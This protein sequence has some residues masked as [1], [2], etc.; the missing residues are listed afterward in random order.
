MAFV[1][2]S[3]KKISKQKCRWDKGGTN[4]TE[5]FKFLRVKRNEIRILAYYFRT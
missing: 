3:C 1:D 2:I 4:V 5:N